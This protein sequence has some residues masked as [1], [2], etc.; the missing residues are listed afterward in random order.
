MKGQHR[1]KVE[2]IKPTSLRGWFFEHMCK[3][4]LTVDKRAEC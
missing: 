2:N 1:K 3:K 4:V